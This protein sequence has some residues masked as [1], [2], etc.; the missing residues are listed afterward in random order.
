MTDITTK[1]NH[2]EQLVSKDGKAR[3]SLQIYFD[4]ITLI[5][6]EDRTSLKPYTVAT[7]P[8]AGDGYG[9]I[10]VTDE[11]GGAVPAFSDLTT[12]R[13]VTDMAVIS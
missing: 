9:L 10:M 7:L 8:S 4:E 3:N 1:P 12:W 6:N 2:G 13:R 11:T 5:M